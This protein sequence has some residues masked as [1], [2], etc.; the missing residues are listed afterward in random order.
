[1]G[2][3]SSKEDKPLYQ[4]PP[5][6]EGQIKIDKDNLP[7]LQ[8][9]ALNVPK[10]PPIKTGAELKREAREKEAKELVA[11]DLEKEFD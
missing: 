10:P 9:K 6:K 7:K 8:V 1:M 11:F 3:S 2:G 5:P 4:P